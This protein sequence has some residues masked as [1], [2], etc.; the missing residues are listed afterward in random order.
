MVLLHEKCY[1]SGRLITGY[2]ANGWDMVMSVFQV[3]LL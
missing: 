3:M 1:K 2:T